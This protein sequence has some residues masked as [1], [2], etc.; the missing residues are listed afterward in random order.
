MTYH[1]IDIQSRMLAALDAKR[2]MHLMIGSIESSL[3]DALFQLIPTGTEININQIDNDTPTYLTTIKILKG[4]SRGTPLFR[5]KNLL[6][7]DLNLDH[8]YLSQ[9]Y[10]DAIPVSMKSGKDMNGRSGNSR[11]L[12]GEA[13]RLVGYFDPNQL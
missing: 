1:S 11:L 5:I 12:D 13:V 8:P 3:F 4:N 6:R 10:A 7:V 9:W 2:S